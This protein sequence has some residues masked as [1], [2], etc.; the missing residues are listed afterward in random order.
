MRTK[1]WKSSLRATKSV[2]EL[3]STIAPTPLPRRD[4]DQTFGGLAA[5]LLGGLGQALL[6]QPV[7]R[8]LDIAVG[9]AQRLLAVHHAGAGLGP[10]I[11]YKRCSY[12]SHNSSLP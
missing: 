12:L 4:A 10:K 3:I 2:S 1:F 11:L 8:R 9:L 5:G 7:D 6:T